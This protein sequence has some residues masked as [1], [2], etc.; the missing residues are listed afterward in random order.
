MRNK[1]KTVWMSGFIGA[2]LSLALSA[3]GASTTTAPAYPTKPIRLVVA[4]PAGGGLDANTRILAVQLTRSLGQQ[5]IVDNRPGANGIIGAQLVAKSASDGYTLLMGA[6][7]ILTNNPNLYRQLPYDADRDFTPITQIELI[8][9]GV[10]VHPAVTA[11]TV[12]ELIALAKSK[13]GLLNFG[14][15][16]I[17][18]FQHLNGELFNSVTG[19][20]LKHIP[21]GSVGPYADLLSGQLAMMFDTF[22]PFL[23]NVKAGK[24]R[25]LAVSGKERRPQLPDV[26]TFIEAAVPQYESYAW[27]GPVA[28]SGTPRAVIARVH[29]AI[30]EAVKAPEVAEKFT[31]VSAGILVAGKPEAFASHIKAE[32]EKVGRLIQR[33]GIKLER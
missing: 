16:G 10:V 32:R 28:P 31:A 2:A 1:T 6:N 29:A 14:S 13:P 4:S 19:I 18:T 26:P 30:V 15:Q 25:A 24:L 7:T 5:V 17:G 23:P 8:P 20:D 12:L 11:K 3:F 27:Y 22:S 33:L 9:V 21:Y